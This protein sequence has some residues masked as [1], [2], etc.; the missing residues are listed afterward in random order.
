MSE[1]LSFTTVRVGAIKVT[2]EGHEL[3]SDVRVLLG[4]DGGYR[5]LAAGTLSEP[6][7]T[8]EEAAARAQPEAS[9][10]GVTCELCWREDGAPLDA[11][12]QPCAICSAVV[13]ASPRYPR[14]LCPACVLEATDANGRLLQFNN[15]GPFCGFE[16]RYRDDES[17]HPGGACWVRGIRCQAEEGR[18]GGIVV[19]PIA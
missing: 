18:F 2:V 7:S 10:P 1:A 19:Q 4:S 15:T 3:E 11:D 8:L 12:E 6:L 9:S 13:A 17:A 14:K 16:A 5:V